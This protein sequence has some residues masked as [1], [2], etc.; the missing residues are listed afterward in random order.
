[1]STDK[2]AKGGFHTRPARRYIRRKLDMRIRISL[3][4]NSNEFIHGRCITISEGGFGAV[5]SAELPPDG[6]IWVE[7][8][9]SN[10]P[11]DTRFRA[12]IR[13]KRGFQ[14]GFQ[15]AAPSPKE[16]I[17]IRQIYGE[18]TEPA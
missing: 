17:Q 2:T 18:G 9:G 5:L 1:M 10:L 3:G 12:E 13:Q 15:F 16:K 6:D 4:P 11:S 14:Y 8:R 7:F